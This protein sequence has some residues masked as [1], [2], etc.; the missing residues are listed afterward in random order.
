VNR[1]VDS[2]RRADRKRWADKPSRKWYPTA[3]WKARR[4]AQL[5]RVPWCEQ[6]KAAGRSRAATVANHNPPHNENEKAFF[7]GPLE[8][9]C[10]ECHDSPIQRAEKE[11]FRRD[12]DGAGW[13]VDP[14]HPFNRR[15]KP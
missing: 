10:K 4:A 5:K 9:V 7:A 13:P 15:S 2:R 12:L 8:S 11:G 6:C 14:N 1:R 3:R